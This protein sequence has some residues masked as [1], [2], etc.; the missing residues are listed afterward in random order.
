MAKLNYAD[1]IA[2]DEKYTALA[3]LSL[4][5]ADLPHQH[6]MTTLIDLMDDQFMPLLAEK[7]SVIGEDGLLLADSASSKRG[8]MRRALELHRYKGTVWAIREVLRQLGFGEIE[9][10]EGLKAR[11][12][13]NSIVQNIP[14]NQRWAY[15]SVRLQQPM[16][17]EQAQRIR[18]ILRN[19]APARCTLAVLD[20]KAVAIRYNNKVRYDGSYNYGV[21]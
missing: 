5:F 19:F 7:W 17:N 9:I 10:D 4:R 16:T 15:Y 2:N 3:D 8:L 12:Y 11:S 14:L 13:E 21:G 1:I 18:Q 6:I 20:Y